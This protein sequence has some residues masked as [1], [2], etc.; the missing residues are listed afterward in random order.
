MSSANAAALPPTAPWWKDLTP[1]HWFVFAM[2]SLAWL[3][4]CLDQQL[5]LIARAGAM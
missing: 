1:Y 5:F 2:A 3:F 4:D